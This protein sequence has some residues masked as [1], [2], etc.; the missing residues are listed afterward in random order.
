MHKKRNSIQD[1]VIERTGKKD[2]TYVKQETSV[3]VTLKT[4]I[5]EA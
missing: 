1:K 5:P 3:K 2:P 4:I